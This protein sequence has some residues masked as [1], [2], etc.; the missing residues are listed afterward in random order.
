MREKNEG[1]ERALDSSPFTA[2]WSELLGNRA[3]LIGRE[4][5]EESSVLPAAQRTSSLSLTHMHAH[6]HI[7]ILA[8]QS[9]MC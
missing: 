3:A 4:A 5:H 2:V 1:Y 7:H 6:A 9:I 8:S